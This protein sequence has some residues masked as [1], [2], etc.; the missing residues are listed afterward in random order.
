MFAEKKQMAKQ[1]LQNLRAEWKV[2]AKGNYVS[3][4]EILNLGIGGMGQQCVILI[5]GCLGLGAGNT[6]LGATLG[7]K[8]MHLQYMAMVQTVLNLIFYII[9][10]KIVDNTKTR[11]GRFRPYIAIM[12]FPI[13]ILATVFIFLPFETMPYTQKLICTFCFAIAISM[14]SPLFTDTYSEL[15]TVITPNSGER[16]KIMSINSLLYSFA[17]TVY[18]AVIPLFADKLGGY[19]DIRTYR[20]VY[21]PIAILGVGLNLFTAFGCK[22][23][24]VTSQN[25]TPKVSLWEG[26][27]EIWKNKHWWIRNIASYIGFLESA[28]GILFS[29]IYIYGTQDMTSYA[30]LTT[31]L[32]SASSIAM[33]ITPW[34]LKKLGNKKLL[35]YHNALNIVFVTMMT[36]TYKI[37]LLLF[38]F[39]YL[40]SLVN[41]LSI[42]YNQVMHSEVKDY[43]QYISG[44]RMDFMFGAAGL[45]GTPITMLTGLVIPYVYECM[46]I[47][48]N[49]DILYDPSVR[50]YIFYVLCIL[51][52][53]GAALNLIPYMFYDLSREKHQNIIRVLYYRSIYDDYTD[54]KLTDEAIIRTVENVRAGIACL[55][56]PAPDLPALKGAL[57]TAKALPKGAE[58]EHAVQAAKEA[59]KAGK[60]LA[61]DKDAAKILQAE[62]EKYDT[63]FYQ[64]LLA[65]AQMILETPIERAAEMDTDRLQKAAAA[66]PSTT[67]EER[68]AKKAAAKNV[69][70]LEKMKCRIQKTYPNGVVRPDPARLNTALDLP[71]ETKAEKKA[72]IAAI[73]AAEKELLQFHKVLKAYL[74]AEALFKR[75]TENKKVYL[76]VEKIYDTRL[77]PQT[78]AAVEAQ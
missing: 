2:P 71:Q 39:I 17:P 47:T 34:L 59:L 57:K 41:A 3:Y 33:A 4:K 74:A 32:G 16:A 43:Q 23:R 14:I 67:K 78:A 63:C 28:C 15:T 53:I 19:T 30:V 52:I 5:I 10:G 36:F 9:R 49:Y 76:E 73:D 75:G 77:A 38:V 61:A 45:I 35:I 51:S 6:L 21:V 66:L 68:Q 70:K 11:F 44:K 42:V 27:F 20:Y 60:Q 8:P 56:A 25:Y 46:G 31:I 50:N 72:K 1:F 69:K 64:V 40:N 62:L 48:T 29:W 24:I 18:Y 13:V 22:E 58:R 7:L 65:Q 12:G 54:D 26:I 37:P 55:N